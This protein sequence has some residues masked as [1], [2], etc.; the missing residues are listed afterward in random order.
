MLV[1]I[2]LPDFSDT[3]TIGVLT[4]IGVC[5]RGDCRF[6]RDRQRSSRIALMAR[7]IAT[8]AAHDRLSSSRNGRLHHRGSNTGGGTEVHAPML[9]QP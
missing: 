6:H 8:A 5:A 9:T 7:G 4:A 2:G 3:M 1:A